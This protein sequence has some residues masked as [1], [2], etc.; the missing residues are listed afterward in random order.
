MKPSLKPGL[1][2]THRV[3][4]TPELTV[5][6]LL[7]QS[8]EFSVMPQVLA[9]GYMVGLFEWTCIEL[10][11]PHLDPGE[12]SLGTHVNFSH[13]AATPPG[14]DVVIEATLTAV[15]GRSLTFEVRGRDDL[16]LIGEGV[17]RRAVVSWERFR[18]KVAEK[19]ARKRA[20]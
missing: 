7:P 15:E 18:G 10:I 17:H 1:S 6:A 11:K 12:G 19:G 5:P 13:V 3:T 20:L 4:V 9:T 8:A 14:F 16:D 2:Y